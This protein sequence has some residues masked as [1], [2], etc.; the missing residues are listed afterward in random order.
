LLALNGFDCKGGYFKKNAYE[1]IIQI[2][3]YKNREPFNYDSSWYDLL[4]EDMFNDSM[5]EIISTKGYLTD[6]GLVTTWLDG[7]VYDYR[8]HS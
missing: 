3:T 7:E 6:N 4:E 1:D 5:S 8:W 2:V